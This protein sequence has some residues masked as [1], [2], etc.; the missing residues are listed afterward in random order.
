[1]RKLRGEPLPER[2]NL[3]PFLPMAAATSIFLEDLPDDILLHILSHLDGP[4]LAAAGCSS[5]HLHR[6]SSL[7]SLW[8]NLCVSN[9]PSLLLLPSLPFSPRSFFS[10]AFPL[11]SSSSSPT[12]QSSPDFVSSFVDLRYRGVPILSRIISTDT[13]SPLFFSSLF[14]LDAID[15]HLRPDPAF[16]PADLEMSWVMVDRTG[17][18]VVDLSSWKPVSMESNW[19]SGDV[20]VRFA[21]AVGEGRAVVVPTVMC[22]VVG[23]REVLLMV[24]DGDGVPMNGTDSMVVIGEMMDG[25]RKGA[26]RRD[27]REGLRKRK[28]GSL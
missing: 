22:S 25:G 11:S 9:Y 18:R 8:L 7:P 2:L 21:T 24:E 19:F 3:L 14:R 15:G 13:R 5:S 20:R 6:L 12:A 23:V 1:M 4:S 17:D 26:R 28:M 27:G 10:L 16:S